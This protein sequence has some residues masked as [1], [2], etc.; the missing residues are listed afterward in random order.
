MDEEIKRRIVETYM[1]REVKLVN[2][3]EATARPVLRV[4]DEKKNVR[5]RDNVCQ[6]SPTGLGGRDWASD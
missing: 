2:G 4:T 1:M 5:Y 6:S 3:E